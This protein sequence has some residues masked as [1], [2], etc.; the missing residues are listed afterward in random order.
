MIILNIIK[1]LPDFIKSIQETFTMVLISGAI[2]LFIGLVIGILLVVTKK[3][4]IL[5]QKY[6]Y[7]FLDKIVNFFR[8]I[9]FIILIALLIPITRMIVGSAI[10]VKGAIVPMVVAVIPFYARQIETAISSLDYGLIEASLAMGFS[11]FEIIKV[12]IRESLASIIRSTT[13][14]IISLIGLST[15]AGAVGAGGIGDFAIRYGYQ[16][17]LEDVT[18]TC[19]LFL[20]V[21]ISLIQ[22]IGDGLAKKVSH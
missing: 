15:M 8:S 20:V 1:L 4:A 6:I 13:I 14:T 19:V 9:P 11:N 21:I 2:G 16:R 18:I 17:S 10:G 5:E 22:K 7:Y 3:D 12:Y